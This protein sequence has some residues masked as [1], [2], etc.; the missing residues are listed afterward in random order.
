M[1]ARY[2]LAVLAIAFLTA[3]AWRAGRSSGRLHPQARVWLLIGIIFGAISIW[4]FARG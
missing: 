2:I 3:G 1:A 4:L